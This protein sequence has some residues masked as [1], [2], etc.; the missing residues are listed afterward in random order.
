MTSARLPPGIL[1]KLALYDALGLV[2]LLLA[3]MQGWLGKI[4]YGDSSGISVFVFVLALGMTGWTYKLAIDPDRTRAESDL[5]MCFRI[6]SAL[7]MLGLIGTVVGG[8]QALLSIDMDAVADV[9]QVKGVFKGFLNGMGVALYATLTGSVLNFFL[10]FHLSMIE[11]H[12]DLEEKQYEENRLTF[13]HSSY[14]TGSSVYNIGGPNAC[15]IV[16]STGSI[17]K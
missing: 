4:V 7:V 6:N 17:G 5:E 1:P 12:F 2:G 10:G 15:P 16:G 13:G 3:W 14:A 9:E 8:S 11:R